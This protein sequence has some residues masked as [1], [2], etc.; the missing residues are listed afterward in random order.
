MRSSSY[1]RRALALAALLAA[2]LALSLLLATPAEARVQSERI[3][4]G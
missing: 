3:I 1:R 4:L 2:V